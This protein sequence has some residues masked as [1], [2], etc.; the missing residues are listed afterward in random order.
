MN[1]KGRHN[2]RVLCLAGMC[3]L[4]LLC[5]NIALGQLTMTKFATTEQSPVYGP[6]GV[7]ATN[8]AV[9]YSVNDCRNI[10]RITSAGQSLFATLP[11]PAGLTGI[12][13]CE[14]YL[15]VSPGIPG[16]PTGYLYATQGP[17]VYEIPPTGGTP[18]LFSTLPNRFGSSSNS[19]PKNFDNVHTSITFDTVGTFGGGLIVT[20]SNGYMGEA[21]GTTT[22]MG[23]FVYK[24]NSTGTATKVAITG[25]NTITGSGTVNGDPTTQYEGPAVAPASN[26]NYPGDLFVAAEY[27]NAVFVISPSGQV[28]AS[29]PANGAESIQF[30]P[31]P[32]SPNNGSCNPDMM[33]GWNFAQNWMNWNQYWGWWSWFSQGNCGTPCFM[34]NFN[35][36]GYEYFQAEINATALG[37]LTS[38]QLAPYAGSAI[39]SAES[40]NSQLSAHGGPF[41]TLISFGPTGAST[42]TFSDPV[43]KGPN[44]HEGGA[45]VI[46]PRQCQCDCWNCQHGDHE[47]CQNTKCQ[48]EQ[49]K[50]Q[51]CQQQCQCQCWNCQ[52]G[53]HQH[54]SNKQCKDVHCI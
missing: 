24:V 51:K 42:Q 36:T 19:D 6:V 46:C 43:S 27:Q 54:C 38:T 8:S 39:V 9:Y 11:G 33:L 26:P 30:I 52:H 53:D 35:N 44:Y 21:L 28:V 7:A 29:I 13:N 32:S 25:N 1:T 16:F 2:T 20:T 48:D 22:G 31:D 40:D 5:T 3:A 47:H 17:Y 10:Y 37:A 15:A 49:C 45:I 34:C 23:T 41:I 12:V 4:P 14:T 50:E 18:T